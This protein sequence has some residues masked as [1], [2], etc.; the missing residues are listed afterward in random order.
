VE[1]PTDP[2]CLDENTA[3]FVSAPNG[4]NADATG[5]TAKPFKTIGAALAKITAAKRRIYICDGTYAEDLALTATHNGV[6]LFGGIDCTFKVVSPNK[7]IIGSTANPV[8]I[9]GTT[10]LAI[11]DVAIEA[12]DATTGSSIAVFVNGG[13]VRLSRVRARAGKGGGASDAV[14]TPITNFPI[15]TDLDGNKAVDGTSGGPEKIVSC[16]GGK[17]TK[18]GKGGDIGNPGATGT[19]GASNAGLVSDCSGIVVGA[20]GAAGTKGLGAQSTGDLQSSGWFPGNGKDGDLGEPGQGGGGG[21][22]NMG[23]GG[24]GGA[25]GCGGAG[26]GGG[27][28][29]GA[30]IALAVYLASVDV[31]QSV[32]E[33]KDAGRGGN[34]AGGQDGQTIFGFRG[35]G[36]GNACNGGAGGPGGKG[37][38]GGGGAGGSSVAVV[39]KGGRPMVD[40]QTASA[41]SVGQTGPL[42][43]GVGANAGVPGATGA[44]LKIN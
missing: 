33:T 30:S 37:G 42:G 23:A 28:G 31:E 11:A 26:G 1:K 8:K 40:A 17:V 24:G 6:S 15:Q 34:G 12:K 38:T 20:T 14:L 7:P 3:L 35:S 43:Q 5:A 13:N 19:P 36:S 4:N 27:K 25:G 41:I 29:G 16:P 32:L 9:D 21:Y 22:G 10:A 2:A 39:Y 18:G 44:E